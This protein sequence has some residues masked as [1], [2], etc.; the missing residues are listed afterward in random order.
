MSNL[1]HS[2]HEAA[3]QH[4]Q[5]GGAVARV[6]V[7]LCADWCGTCREFAPA[8]ARLAAAFPDALFVWLDVEDDSDVAGDIEVD[9]FPTLAVYAD[10]HPVHFGVTL[11]LEPVVHRLLRTLDGA[12]APIAAGAAVAG[13]PQRLF[14]TIK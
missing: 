11:P 2:A 4:A 8:F 10:G 12:A 14:G 3:L 6:V 5:R 13:L 9:N 7:A 1:V